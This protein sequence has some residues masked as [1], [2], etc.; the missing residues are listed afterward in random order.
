VRLTLTP[1]VPMSVGISGRRARAL[2]AR[3]LNQKHGVPDLARFSPSEAS[4]YD[5]RVFELEQY[6]QPPNHTRCGVLRI[7]LWSIFRL[8][9]FTPIIPACCSSGSPSFY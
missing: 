4:D 9:R 5:L 6:P 3:P 1:I 8:S 2:L 7:F